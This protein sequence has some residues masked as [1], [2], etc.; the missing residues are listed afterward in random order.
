[1]YTTCADG[2]L[3][4]NFEYLTDRVV[5]TDGLGQRHE[6]G[7]NDLYL[8]AWEKSP[9]GHLTRYE[10]DDVGNLLQEISPA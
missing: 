10:Y 5:M 4:A 3:T 8:M 7:F 6:Y 9:L 1:M 2:Y